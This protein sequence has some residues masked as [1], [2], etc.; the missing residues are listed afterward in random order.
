MWI[1]KF[2]KP[3]LS[4]F[5]V[6]T[7]LVVAIFLYVSV[8]NGSLSKN[9]NDW[10][11]FGSYLS[12]T[13]GV[14]IAL[15]AVIWLIY[16]VSIQKEEIEKLKIELN[17]SAIEQ[18]QQTEISALT[19]LIS[20]Y[21]TAAQ[22]TQLKLNGCNDGSNHTLKNETIDSIKTQLEHELA[23]VNEYTANLEAKLVKRI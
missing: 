23:K 16:S 6:V 9:S 11:S 14:V 22:V 15:F 4:L 13:A 18:E 20:S 7:T 21:G 5:V 19:A 3:L 12:G 1:K 17:K 10:G 2:W 8:F